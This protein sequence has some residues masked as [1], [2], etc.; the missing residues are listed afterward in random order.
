[1]SI[2]VYT[3]LSPTGNLGGIVCQLQRASKHVSLPFKSE[4]LMMASAPYSGNRELAVC[5]PL[6]P[7]Q[8]SCPSFEARQWHADDVTQRA[9]VGNRPGGDPW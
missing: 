1:M 8:D 9:S 4:L 7:P 2:E 5:R 3:Q 6:V